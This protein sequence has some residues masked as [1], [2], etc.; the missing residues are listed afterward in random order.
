VEDEFREVRKDHSFGVCA[1]ALLGN[2]I[3]S[4]LSR[5]RLI[6]LRGTAGFSL[7]RTPAYAVSYVLIGTPTEQYIRNMI[8]DD[9]G[10]PS[11]AVL[12]L[13]GR[14]Y[15]DLHAGVNFAYTEFSEVALKIHWEFIAFW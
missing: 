12:A 3:R 9:M 13:S 5:T 2:T 1:A 15:A 4:F 10:I 7:A 11:P 6:P 14:G 8:P